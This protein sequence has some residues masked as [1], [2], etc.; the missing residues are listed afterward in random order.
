MIVVP[1]LSGASAH[2]PTMQPPCPEG[3]IDTFTLS[4]SPR[5]RMPMQERIHRVQSRSR[6]R[7]PLQERSRAKFS[8]RLVSRLVRHAQ[9]CPAGAVCLLRSFIL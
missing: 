6:R 1:G 5:P 8:R 3:L 2:K 4:Y 9:G 7:V